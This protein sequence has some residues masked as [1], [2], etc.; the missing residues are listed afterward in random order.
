MKEFVKKF[1]F[2]LRKPFFFVI[3]GVFLVDIFSKILMRRNFENENFDPSKENW[4]VKNLLRLDYTENSGV[5]FSI[6][7]GFPILTTILVF[8]LLI[9]FFYFLIKEN[10]IEVSPIGFGLIFGG[11]IGNVINRLFSKGFVIDFFELKNFAVF[12]IADLAISIGF[13]IA[14][15]NFYKYEKKDK[16]PPKIRTARKIIK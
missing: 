16:N 5:S 7:E 3:F 8:L 9:A 1:N 4:I 13:L 12:N 15:L 11:S 14:L 6:F 2:K 10:L